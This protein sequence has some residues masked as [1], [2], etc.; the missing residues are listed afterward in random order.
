MSVADI[1]TAM[2]SAASLLAAGDY[3]GAIDQALIAKAHLIA[4]P[5]ATLGLGKNGMQTAWRSDDVDQ[6]IAQC[7]RRRTAAKG[8]QT[9]N[10]AYARPTT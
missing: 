9:S 10:I 4:L 1:Q 7:N 6:F 5:D 8:I 2:T 3:A